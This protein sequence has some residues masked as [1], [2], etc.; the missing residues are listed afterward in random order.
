MQKKMLTAGEKLGPYEVVRQIGAGGMGSVYEARDTRLGRRVA[1]KVLNVE[2]T[3]RFIREAKAVGALNHPNICT[4]YDIGP[5]YLVMEYVEGSPLR[6]PLPLETAREFAVQIVDAL[7]AAHRKGIVHR[8]LKPGNILRTESG[9]KLLDFGLAKVVATD[10]DA[11]TEVLQFET[12]AGVTLGTFPYMSPEQAEGRSVDVR[13]DIFSFGTVLYELLA[14]QR[15]FQGD[16]TASVVAALL[17]DHPA[18]LH[19]VR[20]EVPESVAEIVARCLRKKADERF[21]TAAELKSALSRAQWTAADQ[22]VSVAVLPFVNMNHDE[23]GEFFADGVTEDII[24]ALAK[25]PGLRVVARSSA[26]QFKGRA[27]SHDEVREKLKVS[28]IV[29]GSVRRAGQRIRV[30]AELINATDGFQMWSERYDRVMEDVFA[31]QDE[32]SRA[33]AAK[34]EVKLGAGQKV[35]VNRTQNMEAYN[36]YLRGR[37]HWLKRTPVGYRQAEEYFRRAVA[38]GPEFAPSHAGLADCLSIGAFYGA[39]KAASAIMEAREL[40]GRALAIDGHLP[41]AHTSLGFLELQVLNFEASEEHFSL[42]H[43]LKPNQALTVFWHSCLRSAAG[44]LDEAVEMAHKAVQLEPTVAVYG[45]G[46]SLTILYAG[47][48]AT[49]IEKGRKVLEMEPGFPLGQTILGQALAEGGQMDEGIHML[50]SATPAMAPGG[51]WGRGLLGHYLGRSGDMAGARQILDELLVLRKNAYAQ[52]IAIAA[53]YVGLGERDLAVEWLGQAA[54]E[55][56][57][58]HIWTPIDPLWKR[59]L[60]HPGMPK[61][62]LRWPHETAPPD[63]QS[64]LD[65]HT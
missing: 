57:G 37:H 65:R 29:E 40:L 53:V 51:Y 24:S 18:S 5:N 14:G 56:G 28:A 15:P 2:F 45:A 55:P 49:A 6:G 41:E 3:D 13:S 36:L 64:L 54:Q 11:E 25:L 31:I 63:G 35:V 47:R 10:P 33:I 30:T 50:R 52:A 7:D 39:R 58:L 4:L 34:L 16:T 43:Q 21:Q 27:A 44:R 9:I 62:L 46:E 59:L 20:A 1:L 12:Q 61:I 60:S 17:R 42:A 32:I 8:D 22:T 23:D 38:E 26:F 48:S 19:K